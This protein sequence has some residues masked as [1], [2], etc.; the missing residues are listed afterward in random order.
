MR[1]P[2]CRNSEHSD[3]HLHSEGFTEDIMRCPSCGAVWAI[4][5]GVTEIVKDPQEKSFLSGASECV[6]GDDYVLAA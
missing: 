6:E 1:C 3:I 5:H 2:V 4:N